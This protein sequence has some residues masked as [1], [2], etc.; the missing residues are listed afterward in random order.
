[1]SNFG[2]KWTHDKRYK[3]GS[4]K[5]QDNMIWGLNRVEFFGIV[6]IFAIQLLLQRNSTTSI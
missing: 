6:P 5:P 2:A 3:L 1:M 4:Q